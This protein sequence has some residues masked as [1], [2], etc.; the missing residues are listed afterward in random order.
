MQLLLVGL[1]PLGI[2]L[3]ADVYE[4]GLGSIEAAVDVSPK[5]LGRSLLDLV[6]TSKSPLRVT[7]DL[8][9]AGARGLDAAVVATSSSL[10]SCAPTLCTLLGRGMC[11]VSTCEELFWPWLRHAELARELDDLAKRCGGRLLGTGVNPGFV[12]DAFCL[13]LTAVS[14]AVDSIEV[15]RYQDATT[16]RIPFQK[17]IGVSLEEA[18]FQA[19]VAA[20]SLRHV[21]LGESLHFLASHLGWPVEHWEEDIAPVYASRDLPSGLGMVPTGKICGVRQSARGRVGGRTRIEL[22]FQASLGLE[23]PH[24]RTIVRGEPELDVRI[25]NG[26]HGDVATSAITLN[27]IRALQKAPPGLHSMA[28]IPMVHCAKAHA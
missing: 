14:R 26:V 13:G 21:G 24:D 2:K 10:V 4:R 19:Q 16:R 7:G 12:M 9:A 3:A 11:V 25:Q 20:G 28:S 23:D 15:H 6:P 17:K 22:K 8:E 18:Q 27:A 5:L 1:G